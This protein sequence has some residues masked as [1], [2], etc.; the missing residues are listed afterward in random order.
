[1]T[2]SPPANL[3]SAWLAKGTITSCGMMVWPGDNVFFNV[4]Y[5]LNDTTTSYFEH[6]LTHLF[7]VGI[8]FELDRAATR[9]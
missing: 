8:G 1:M 6:N 3:V 7:S 4:G 2:Q 5:V 9:L